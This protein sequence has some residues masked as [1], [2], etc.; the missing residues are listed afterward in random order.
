MTEWPNSRMAR[1]LSGQ[2]F[3]SARPSSCK[4]R[5]KTTLGERWP[6][7]HLQPR[8]LSKALRGPA[9]S[10]RLVRRPKSPHWIIRGTVRRVRVE[11]SSG[12][13]DKRVAEGV[14]AKR[15]A[16]IL[17]ELSLRSSRYRYIR[18]GGPELFGGGRQQEI[19]GT[20]NQALRHHPVG[21]NRPGRCGTGPANSTRWSPLQ[22]VIANFI[23][24]PRR[25]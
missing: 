6:C 16:Q 4:R 20:C 9:M 21:Q 2:C 12:T 8:R 22:P 5:A 23:H 10:L 15:E 14:G 3:R 1:D 25:C 17:A 19:F 24:P 18:R 7:R 13:S 11:E